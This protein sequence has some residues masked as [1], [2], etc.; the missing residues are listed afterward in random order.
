MRTARAKGAEERVVIKR[1]A[2]RN[3]LLPIATISGLTFAALLNGVVIT[4]FVFN[5]PGL[6]RWVLEAVLIFD[7]P[8]IL[9][10][11][12]FNAVLLVT[13]NLVVDILYAYIDPRV[14]LG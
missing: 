8:G 7:Y 14:R 6:G 1:H 4:E 2:R 10:F 3:A 9:G 11:T 12:L 13:A 5:R